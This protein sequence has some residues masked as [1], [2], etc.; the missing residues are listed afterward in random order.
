MHGGAHGVAHAIVDLFLELPF[1][2]GQSTLFREQRNG[3]LALLDRLEASLLGASNEDPEGV[4]LAADAEID[5]LAKLERKAAAKLGTGRIR[6]W[7]G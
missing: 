4:T 7:G 1:V 6:P 5:A 2:F 3:K